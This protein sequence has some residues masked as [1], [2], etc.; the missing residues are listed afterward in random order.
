MWFSKIPAKIEAGDCRK[1]GVAL[2]NMLRWEII[3]WFCHVLPQP[4]VN[5]WVPFDIQM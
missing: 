1:E 5:N 4:A 2:G 3:E